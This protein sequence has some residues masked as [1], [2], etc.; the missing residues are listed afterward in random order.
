MKIEKPQTLI[1]DLKRPFHPS[2]ISWRV[3]NT[4]K[5]KVQRETGNQNAPATKGQ[6]LAYIDARD[7]LQRLDD[8]CGLDW[9][10]DYTVAT[11]SGLLVCRIGI[12]INENWVWRS[13]GAGDTQVEA[14]KGKCSD[15]FK[16]AAVNWGIG[17][18]L[19]QLDAP[20]VDLENGFLPR[21]F[22]APELPAWATPAGYNSL[23]EQRDNK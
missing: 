19:Y 9:Q 18:Y 1:D 13:N 21:N 16:R 15:A 8:V 3:G 10:N 6:V 12:L 4:N 5:K 2:K 22:V 11:E 17:R 7:V 14:E 20:W 23:L